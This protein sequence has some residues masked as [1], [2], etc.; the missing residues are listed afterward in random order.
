MEANYRAGGPVPIHAPIESTDYPARRQR[1]QCAG[2]GCDLLEPAHRTGS[3][4]LVCFAFHF[5]SARGAAASRALDER[6][7]VNFADRP[8][9]RHR[10]GAF[11]PLVTGHTIVGR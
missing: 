5:F 7:V 6:T 8:N 10:I 1:T 4:R 9:S 2:P 11:I 3:V